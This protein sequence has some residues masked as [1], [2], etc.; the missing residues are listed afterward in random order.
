MKS[1]LSLIA[2]SFLSLLIIFA[3]CGSPAG[4]TPPSNTTPSP[5]NLY[6]AIESCGNDPEGKIVIDDVTV[7][8]GTLDRDY[9]TPAA[10]Q[11]LAGEACFLFG[12]NIKNGYNEDCW[13][14]Y[15]IE[16]FDASGNLVSW[17]LDTGPQP[18]WG[19][20]YIAADSSM[21]FTLHLTWSDNVTD[22]L[23]S[24]QRTTRTEP[25]PSPSNPAS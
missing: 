14:A 12:G 20:V 3:G 8:A 21:P 2:V 19:Q 15:H 18:G 16:G 17:T 6:V 11:H 23:I 22:F 4:T 10:G 24:S 5:A 25:S 13:V 1:L 9:F 7:T